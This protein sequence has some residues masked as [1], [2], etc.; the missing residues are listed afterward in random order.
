MPRTHWYFLL[1]A[2]D[3]RNI[4]TLV[5]RFQAWFTQ[6]G[7]TII[8]VLLIGF[9]SAAPGLALSAYLLPCFIFGLLFTSWIFAFFFKPNVQAR[10]IINHQPIAGSY[11][12]YSVRVKNCGTRPARNIDVFESPLPFGLYSDPYHPKHH[13]RIDFLA[14]G[15]EQTVALVMRCPRRGIYQLPHLIIGSNFPSGLLRI[16][17]KCPSPQQLTVLPKIET[18]TIRPLIQHHNLSALTGVSSSRPGHS[19]EFF[20]TREYRHGERI[21]D[22]HWASSARTGKLIV[23]EYA[24]EQ[25]SRTGIILDAEYTFW[26]RIY[27]LEYSISLIGSLI[28]YYMESGVIV[29]TFAFGKELFYQ[30]SYDPN[31]GHTQSVWSF[32]SQIEDADHVDFTAYVKE[33][34]PL[35]NNLSNVTIFL[36]TWDKRREKMCLQLKESGVSLR[37]M[38]ADQ[39]CPISDNSTMTITRIPGPIPKITKTAKVT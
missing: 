14:P 9:A 18:E 36:K 23:K 24:H 26:E 35:L 16:P 8:T 7:K 28:E 33:T 34:L 37:I 22:I 27:A 1:P 3:H 10:R 20:G 6:E 12:F 11:W 32:L 21:R 17:V 15:E 5:N 13:N 19:M 2:Q 31:P 39:T 4:K 29:D 25:L 30:Q 38:I